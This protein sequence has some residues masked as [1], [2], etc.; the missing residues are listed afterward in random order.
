MVI[1]SI[2]NEHG[3]LSVLVN[4]CSSVSIGTRLHAEQQG[5]DSQQGQENYSLCHRVQTG[6]EVHPTSYPMGAGKASGRRS[7]RGVKLTTHLHP[8]FR[9]RGTIAPLLQYVF[10]ARCLVKDKDNFSLPYHT[11][12]TFEILTHNRGQLLDYRLTESELQLYF[13]T[14]MTNLVQYIKQ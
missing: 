6:S 4:C 14:F 2:K 9:M 10:I 1:K 5:F 11:Y 12:S 7:G 8:R 3:L 13:N